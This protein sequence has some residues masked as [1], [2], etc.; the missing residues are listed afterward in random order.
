MALGHEAEEKG[1]DEGAGPGLRGAARGA[2]LAPGEGQ[3]GQHGAGDT[4][5]G[6]RLEGER[7]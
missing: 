7:L 1:M 2:P 3:V 6:V 5:H 4:V